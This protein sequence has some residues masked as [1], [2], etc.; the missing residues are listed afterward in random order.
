MIANVWYPV[1]YFRISFGKQDRLGNI[2]L[3]IQAESGLE[4][5]ASEHE[6]FSAVLK[7]LAQSSNKNILDNLSSLMR[8]VPYRFLRPWFKKELK[9]VPDYRINSGIVDL[10]KQRFNSRE[11]LCLYKFVGKDKAIEI[12]KDWF[13]Y[14]RKHS[15]IM[16]DF[17]YWNLLNYLQK[18]N[19]NVPNIAEKLFAPNV[20][21]LNAARKYWD[22]I[23]SEY[24]EFRCIYSHTQI[25][26][27]EFSIDHFVPWRFVTHDLLWNLVP[28]PNFVNSA[29]SDS[30]P[31]IDKYFD[32]F[33]NV[34]YESFRIGFRKN[35]TKMLEDYA[36]LYQRA[37]KEIY[38]MPK[39]T[40]A[41]RLRSTISPLI[42]IAEN[43]GFESGWVFKQ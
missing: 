20:R 42:Q 22:L 4:A 39:E 30:L 32:K 23:L 10:A 40:F 8:Y 18:N 5:N 25:S 17:C 3:W 12:Q 7:V 43:M 31:A 29:K 15:R 21:S 11:D 1:N 14:L 27:G 13:E 35:K 36:N 6:V 24:G 19:S 26:E 34:Q 41:E 16:M 38:E 9:G 33:A 28:V 37:L 2:A